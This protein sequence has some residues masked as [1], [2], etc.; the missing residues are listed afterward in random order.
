MINK[1]VPCSCG[2]FNIPCSCPSEIFYFLKLIQNKFRFLNTCTLMYVSKSS[3][4]NRARFRAG[5]CQSHW[6]KMF[7]VI[8]YFPIAERHTWLTCVLLVTSNLNCGPPLCESHALWDFFYRNCLLTWMVTLIVCRIIMWK[9]C[10]GVTV[11][12]VFFQN[13]ANVWVGMW[14]MGREDK[15]DHCCKLLL[16]NCYLQNSKNRYHR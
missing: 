2:A 8:T 9:W 5:E 12:W 15:S 1:M 13:L 14:L 6:G 3:K 11:A 7:C 16:R 10:L 4:E